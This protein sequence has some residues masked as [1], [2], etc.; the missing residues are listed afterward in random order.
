MTPEL[1][2]AVDVM[3]AAF[4]RYQRP[5]TFLGCGCCFEGVPITGEFWNGTYRSLVEVTSPGGTRPL[6]ELTE[7]DGLR[8]IVTDVPLTGGDQDLL[9]HYLPRLCEIAVGDDEGWIDLLS[10]CFRLADGPDVAAAQWWT[11]P[12][13]EVAAVRGFLDAVWSSARRAER[14][15][16]CASKLDSLLIAEIDPERLC[17]AWAADEDPEAQ[18]NLTECRELLATGEFGTMF[19]S[20]DGQEPYSANLRALV[21][22]L[23]ALEV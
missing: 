14:L 16:G 7:D 11:W 17:S 5:P 3:Y 12:S 6:P 15:W 21:D 9:K 8:D 23:D 20:P 22:W 18:R 13:E 10:V 19:D 2:A 1:E 4:A